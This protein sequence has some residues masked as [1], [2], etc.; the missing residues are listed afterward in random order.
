[1]NT[2]KATRLFDRHGRQWVAKRILQLAKEIVECDSY[3]RAIVGAGQM[4]TLAELCKGDSYWDEKACYGKNLEEENLEL[5]EEFARN[6]TDKP[7]K[8]NSNG[9]LGW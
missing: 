6:L 7:A 2:R 4:H 1:M 9:N 3:K 5:C 8:V